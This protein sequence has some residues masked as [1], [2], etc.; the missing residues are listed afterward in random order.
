MDTLKVIL[1]AYTEDDP[2]PCSGEYGLYTLSTDK[3]YPPYYYKSQT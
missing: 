1:K 3:P 2:N